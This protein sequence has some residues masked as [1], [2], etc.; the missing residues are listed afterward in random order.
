MAVAGLAAIGLALPAAPSG[1]A[2]DYSA[3]ASADGIRV[4]V[5]VRR[6]LVVEQFVDAGAPSAQAHIDSLGNSAAWAAYPFPSDLVISVPGTVAGFGPA[7][8]PALPEYPFYASASHP[9]KGS[10]AFGNESF[11][12]QAKAEEQVATASAQAGLVAPDVRLGLTRS[13]ASAGRAAGGAVEAVSESTVEG[14][15]VGDVLRIGRVHS[16]AVA[17]ARPGGAAPREGR[18]TVAEMTVA[19]QTVAIGPDGLQA[20]GGAAPLP[21]SA[22]A[23]QALADA[24][25]SVRYLAP[26]QS[27]T[28]VVAAGVEVQLVREISGVGEAVVS[29]VLGRASAYADAAA[30]PLV[31]PESGLPSGVPD[32][33]PSLSGAGNLSDGAPSAD[34]TTTL[35]GDGLPLGRQ[36]SVDWGGGAVAS[37]PAG[38]AAATQ[39][40][41]APDPPRGLESPA[42]GSSTGPSGAAVHS[43][44]A[45]A[46]VPGPD[47]SGFLPILAAGGAVVAGAVIAAGRLMRRASWTS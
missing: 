3:T 19:G 9:T 25:V 47:F 43:A 15:A 32:P 17:G 44:P 2:G 30:D 27:E 14:F 41:L 1:A 5:A 38:M 35:S 7:G 37:A 24:G 40:P 31:A 36:A 42:T 34:A 26:I 16:R 22:P 29:Y 11:A 8:L 10:S 46:L 21:D 12:L 18:T 33:E 4:G 6:F 23:R 20:P 39:P 45:A 13:T 28:G